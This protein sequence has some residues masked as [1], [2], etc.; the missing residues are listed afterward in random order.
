[1]IKSSDHVPRTAV[2]V[3]FPVPRSFGVSQESRIEREWSW[4]VPAGAAASL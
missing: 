1:M 3:R 4:P 2:L